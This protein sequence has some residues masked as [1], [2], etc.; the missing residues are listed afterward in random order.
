MTWTKLWS[1]G[2]RDLGRNRRRSIFTMLAV[3]LGLRAPQGATVWAVDVNERARGL[4]SE[5][6]IANGVGDVV[7]VVAPDQVPADLLVDAVVEAR[8][9][10]RA[11]SLY[12]RYFCSK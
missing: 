4:C 1:I 7:R 10:P 6:A 8:L 3:A 11:I 9:S 5:N 2:Y 12:Q